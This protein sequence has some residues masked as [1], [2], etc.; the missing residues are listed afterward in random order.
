MVGMVRENLRGRHLRRGGRAALEPLN[1][2]TN[3]RCRPVAGAA[4]RHY[5]TTTG[6]GI[7]RPCHTLDR[8]TLALRRA[9]PSRFTLQPMGR[10]PAADLLQ[11]APP[12]GFRTT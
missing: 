7:A 12:A 3:A 1:L 9:V 4:G 10:N 5:R 11:M 6:C 8:H 2:K